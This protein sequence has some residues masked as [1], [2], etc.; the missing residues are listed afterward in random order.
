[1]I[2]RSDAIG[3]PFT[4]IRTKDLLGIFLYDPLMY[5]NPA[6]TQENSYLHVFVFLTHVGHIL[7]I[8]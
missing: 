4:V 7:D 3:F 1:M 8:L 2:A 5:V 6:K